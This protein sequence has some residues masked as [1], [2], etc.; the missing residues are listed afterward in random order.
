MWL[1]GVWLGCCRGATR[2]DPWKPVKSSLPTEHPGD[3]CVNLRVSYKE[4]P[5]KIGHRVN[6]NIKVLYHLHRNPNA[7][8]NKTRC[9]FF[10]GGGV[11]TEAMWQCGKAC[12][13]LDEVTV[14]L[15]RGM[16]GRGKKCSYLHRIAS[17][18]A[19]KS[20]SNYNCKVQK[21]LSSLRL[22]SVF[23]LYL[24]PFLDHGYFE[25]WSPKSD[26]IRDC[27]AMFPQTPWY[28]FHY[29]CE[30]MWQSLADTQHLG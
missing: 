9:V 19:T 21:L 6:T 14:R 11:L 25:I 24:T 12:A 4:M 13:L 28:W 1:V 7:C 29:Y 8:W 5:A 20:S 26:E 10:Q 23:L 16:K 3:L 17:A 18:T 30:G 27:I 22:Q 2:L 15:S